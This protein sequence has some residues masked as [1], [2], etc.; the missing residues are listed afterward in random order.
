MLPA[1][2]PEALDKLDGWVNSLAAS[3]DPPIRSALPEGDFQ[4]RFPDESIE[5][6][7][8]CKAVR[9]STALGAAWELA[10]KAYPTE[11]GSLMR[12]V[13]DF[14]SEINFMAE[15]VVEGRIT[16]SQQEFLDQFFR[17]LHRTLDDFLVREREY[18]V[19]RKSI[20]KVERGMLEKAGG[21]AEVFEHLSLYLAYGLNKYVH[22]AYETA[23]EIYHGGY[24]RF[25]I[26]GAPGR[27]QEASIRMVASKATEALHAVMMVAIALQ[28]P[29]VFSEIQTFLDNADPSLATW[30][31]PS[32]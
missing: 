3:L 31:R 5:V 7:L 18:Y 28:A 16:R 27:P 26:R 14:A 19:S 24:H 11:A 17:P 9:L 32:Y 2:V 1:S 10:Q 8:V 15:T 23:M 22:G 25:M 21:D 12:A 6:L 13:G 20:G 4:W 30:H 29:E